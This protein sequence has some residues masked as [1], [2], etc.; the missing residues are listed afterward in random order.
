[1]CGK[2]VATFS[3]GSFQLWNGS[4]TKLMVPNP[5]SLIYELLMTKQ[6][7]PCSIFV[8]HRGIIWSIPSLCY[9]AS[10]KGGFRQGGKP[11]DIPV[12]IFIVKC[13]IIF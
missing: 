6:I 5:D 4:S 1:M 10:K 3:M 11:I 13:R 7:V 12:L 9:F 8:Y 2:L